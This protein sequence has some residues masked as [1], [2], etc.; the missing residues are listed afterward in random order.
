MPTSVYRSC[1]RREAADRAVIPEPAPD[2]N[3]ELA[4][5]SEILA[6]T[7]TGAAA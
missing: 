7:E 5:R 6:V 2:A 1:S 3:S 4:S